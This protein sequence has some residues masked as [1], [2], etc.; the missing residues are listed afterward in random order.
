MVHP[1]RPRSSDWVGDV[2]LFNGRNWYEAQ[3]RVHASTAKTAVH[4]AAIVARE[5]MALPRP[6]RTLRIWMQLSRVPR[7]RRSNGH[8]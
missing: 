2:R 6:F 3:V 8:G 7:S 4:R 1:L 5:R